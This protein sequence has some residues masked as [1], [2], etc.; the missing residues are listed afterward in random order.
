MILTISG[1]HPNLQDSKSKYKLYEQSN[2]IGQYPPG[3]GK[4]IL[5]LY[6]PYFRIY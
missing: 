5:N 1:N 2:Y 6:L 4:L 3:F